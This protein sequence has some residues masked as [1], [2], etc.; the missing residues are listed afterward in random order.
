LCWSYE[1]E[2]PA[3]RKCVMLVANFLNS[4]EIKICSNN[5]LNELVFISNQSYRDHYIHLWHD[6]GEEYIKSNFSSLKLNEELSDPNSIFYLIRFENKIVGY[7]KLN[8]DKGIEKYSST[9]ALELERIYFIKNAV[10]KGFGKLIIDFVI[11]YARKKNKKIVWLK[12]MNSSKAVDFYKKQ[13]FYIC[14]EYFLAFP[15]MKNEFKKILVMI[16]EI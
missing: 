11:D 8:I 10:G 7:F 12:S 16:K 5:E 14:N 6:N 15:T 4:M 13:D 1:F 2:F 9:V 3:L